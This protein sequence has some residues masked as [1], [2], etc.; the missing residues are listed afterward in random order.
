MAM[1]RRLFLA[2]AASVVAIASSAPARQPVKAIAFD[3][4]PVIDPTPVAVRAEECFPGH[5]EALMNAWRGRQFE[6]TWLRTVAGRYTDFWTTTRD[7]LKFAAQSLGLPLEDQARERLM[8]AYLELKAWPDARA[9]LQELRDTGIR[10]AFLSNFSSAMLDSAVHNSQ[11]SGLFDEHLSTDRVR[12]FKPDARAYGMA[13]KAFRASREEIVF[14]ASAG[15]DAAGAKWFGYRAFWVNRS[16]QVAEEL[17][18]QAD[19][20]G[21]GMQDLVHFIQAGHGAAA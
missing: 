8:Q 2:S 19:G 1:D 13:L 9:A 14:C 12:A 21:A 3:A 10:L 20:T 18:V 15:W 17:G 6:Y 11:L 5:G 16:R 4:F 7:A